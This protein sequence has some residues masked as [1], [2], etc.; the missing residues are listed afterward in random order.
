MN[1]EMERSVSVWMSSGPVLEAPLLR[2]DERADVAVVGAG[3][4]GLSAAYELMRA[5]RSVVVIDR[6]HIGGGM[7]SRTTGHLASALDDYYH[8][9]IARSGIEAA[10][11]HYAAHAAA[12]DRIEQIARHEGI[13]CDFARLDGY[14]FLAPGH[15]ESLLHREIEACER[16]GYNGVRWVEHAPVPGV[17]T[18]RA[19]QFPDQARFHPRK[20]LAGLAHAILRDGGRIYANTPV[21][22]FH[23]TETGVVL[24]AG[25]NHRIHAGNVVVATNSPVNDRVAV[26]T[27]QAPYRTYAIAG[28]V[29]AGSVPDAL[30][31]DTLDAY[32]YVRLH[33]MGDGMDMLIVGGND[34]KTGEAQ[35]MGDRFADLEAWTRRHYPQL[36]SV[37][38]RWSGQVMEPVDYLPFTGRNHGNHRIFIHTGDSGQGLTNGVAGAMILRDLIIGHE[39]SWAE[40][41]DPQRISLTA[42]GEFL[43]ENLDAATHWAEHLTG[44][45]V[46]STNDIPPGQGAILRDGLKKLAIFRD[47]S[48]TLHVR[49]AACSHAGCVVHWNPFERCWDCPCHGSHFAV[50]GSVL[51]G[52]AITPLAHADYQE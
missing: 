15:D 10:R 17:E 28:P 22:G 41:T 47:E 39:N 37:D 30:V 6:G 16:I 25:H 11:R 18:G 3:I 29:E 13:A 20:Y 4:A 31:W 38:Y 26:H 14:L 23:E 24:T 44:G 45:E 8:Q 33:P 50:D 36:G 35:D 12:I 5:G 34:H 19:L 42:A 21:T 52:P 49:S 43:K 27:K 32:H 7:S 9:L 2:S 40:V 46:G 48:G 1:V 51:N